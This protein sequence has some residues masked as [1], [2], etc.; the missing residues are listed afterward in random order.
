MAAALVMAAFSTTAATV[1]LNLASGG[2]DTGYVYG[3]VRTF[4]TASGVTVTA[5]AWSLTGGSNNKFESSY[6]G[7]YSGYGLGVCN[8]DEQCNNSDHRVDNN[9]RLDFVLFQFSAAVDPTIVTINPS[10][11][12]FDLDASYWTGT[13]TNLS[14]A[15]K[16]LNNLDD[17]GLGDRKGSEG[18]KSSSPRNVTINSGLVNSMLFGADIFDND[19]W[20]K[21][22]SITFNYTP[23]AQVPEPGS[24]ALIALAL[25]G[26]GLAR[27]RRAA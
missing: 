21:I 5:S 4:S 3:N 12:R 25:G 7:Q 27:R 19:D 26:L 14:L 9:G 8:R 2:T 23:P 18:D 16:T 24:L 10:G 22:A 11:E 1:S 6:L 17:V 15:G 13:T 20:F